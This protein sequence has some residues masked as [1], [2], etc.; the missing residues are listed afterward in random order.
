MILIEQKSYTNILNE[1]LSKLT[2]ESTI[3][4]KYQLQLF[5]LTFGFTSKIM[6]N[7]LISA[8]GIHP[9][10][11]M[12]WM[13]NH[14]KNAKIECKKIENLKWNFNWLVAKW[15]YTRWNSIGL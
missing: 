10:K 2:N 8:F 4:L 13:R 5:P 15:I 6:E 3:S 11:A 9:I 7:N 12:N 14:R 1:I